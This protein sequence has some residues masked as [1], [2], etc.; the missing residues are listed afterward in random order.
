MFRRILV[1]LDGSAR[2]ERA[3]PVAV[4]L[5]RASGG[6]IFLIRVVSTAPESMPSAPAKPILIQ[7]VG[8]EDIALAESYLTAIAASEELRDMSVRTEAFVGLVAPTILSTAESQFI[9]VIVMCSHGFT[10]AK[11]WVLGSVSEKVA[12][13]SNIPVLVL[14]E[15]GSMLAEQTT[16]AQPMRVLVPLDGSENALSALEPAS[17]LATALSAPQQGA[18]HLL[19]VVKVPVSANGAKTA[20]GR[21]AART[22]AT[23]SRIATTAVN[24]VRANHESYVD[25]NSA[26]QYLEQV[27]ARIH[28]K[29]LAPSIADT[30]LALTWSVTTEEDIAQ[31]IIRGGEQGEQAAGAATIDKAHVIAMTTHGYNTMQPT[32][33]GTIPGRVLHAS[34]VPVLI[35]RPGS[36]RS[37]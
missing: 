34:H 15:D 31:A 27:V 26:Q 28:D 1:P 29:S 4:R 10:G 17:Y 24:A 11:R 6:T 16:E 14:R 36:M 12:R 23:A 9:D 25:V 7:T 30:N 13:S 21:V 33:I 3:L 5:A 20:A 18:L 32:T 19:H 8:P 2:A 35:I 22:R 37:Q